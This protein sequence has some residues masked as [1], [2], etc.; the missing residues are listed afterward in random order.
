[1]KKELKDYLHLYLGCEL[2]SISTYEIVGKLEGIVGSEAHFKVNGVWYSASLSNYKPILRP[3]SDMTDEEYDYLAEHILDD[4][5]W[6][7]ATIYDF[8][9]I[10]REKLSISKLAET[11]YYLLSKHF[12]LFGLIESGLAID[13]SKVKSKM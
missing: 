5:I 10:L 7:P 11:N 3:L 2:L 13:A 12:D 9:N 4:I 1:M 6:S 8:I